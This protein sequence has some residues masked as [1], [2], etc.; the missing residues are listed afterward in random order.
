MIGFST[1]S[2]GPQWR[3]EW[4][5]PSEEVKG[6]QP[7]A[8]QTTAVGWPGEWKADPGGVLEV[9]MPHP[10]GRVDVG[11]GICPEDVRDSS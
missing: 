5:Q 1:Q 6:Q 9:E 2:P 11:A 7:M 4:E 3:L 10:W 8:A